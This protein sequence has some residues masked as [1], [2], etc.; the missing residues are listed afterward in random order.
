MGICLGLFF[1]PN[2]WLMIFVR[3]V[4]TFTILICVWLISTSQCWKYCNCF[5]KI[6]CWVIFCYYSIC[7]FT[8]WMQLM[9]SN[10]ALEPFPV[11]STKLF[12]MVDSFMWTFILLMWHI[13]D[14]VPFAKWSLACFEDF[15]STP[16]AWLLV[17]NGKIRL[18]ELETCDDNIEM[19][20]LKTSFLLLLHM[21]R[22]S[23]V[24]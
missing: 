18:M 1:L 8:D 13:L 12:W 3:L 7:R 5:Y 11:A 14:D 4:I 17:F 24:L 10:K 2:V 20:V 22:C 21:W 23:R 19:M 15:V 16:F 9:D 6:S